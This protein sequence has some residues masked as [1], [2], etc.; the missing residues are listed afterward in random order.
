[1]AILAWDLVNAVATHRHERG[2]GNTGSSRHLLTVERT[3]SDPH[4]PVALPDQTNVALRDVFDRKWL[5]DRRTRISFVVRLYR[6]EIHGSALKH[7]VGAEDIEH[8][9]R[10]RL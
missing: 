7:G 1:V 4:R 6:V 3:T 9:V 10:T 8:A 2:L 5:R